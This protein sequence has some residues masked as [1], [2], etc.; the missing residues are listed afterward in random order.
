MVGIFRYKRGLE[1][2][3]VSQTE[4]TAIQALYNKYASDSEK[5]WFSPREWWEHGRKYC[6]G[7]P[8]CYEIKPVQEM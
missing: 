6:N 1:L 3:A 7:A 8:Q 2:V 5:E 4:E